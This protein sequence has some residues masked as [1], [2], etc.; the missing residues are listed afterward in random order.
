MTITSFLSYASLQ[1]C[2]NDNALA[3]I[4]K[5]CS[6][7]SSI[8][9]E[10]EYDDNDD[11]DLLPTLARLRQAFPTPESH[12]NIQDFLSCTCELCRPQHGALE[13]DDRESQLSHEIL[14]SDEHLKAFVTLVLSGCL[15]A[16]REF[17]KSED[18]LKTF[19]RFIGNKGAQARR[20]LFGF[21][22]IN[23]V[24]CQHTAEARAAIPLSLQCLACVALTFRSCI[25][26]KSRLQA[27]KTLKK[28]ERIEEYVLSTANLPIVLE[29]ADQIEKPFKPGVRFSRCRIEST[30][31]QSEELTV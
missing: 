2:K 23:G 24:Q 17:L 5:H 21:I 13:D 28:S 8:R 14:R 30:H 1:K 15:F 3:I 19:A 27:I 7:G 9:R 29:H 4:R 6:K 25:G 22:D 11:A 20:R 12:I 10:G 18:D 31:C 26:R 16:L